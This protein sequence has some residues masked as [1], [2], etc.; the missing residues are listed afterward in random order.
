MKRP[1][2]LSKNY[3]R[4]FLSEAGKIFFSILGGCWLLTE[5]LTFFLPDVMQWAS[6]NS[7]VFLSSVTLALLVAIIYSLMKLWR[8]IGAH[9]ELGPLVIPII[10]TK[11][12]RIQVPREVMA[13]EIIKSF[14]AATYSERKFCEK[15]TLVI[16][17]EDHDEHIDLKELGNY[18]HV[19][20]IQKRWQKEPVGESVP[21]EE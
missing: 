11:F 2:F 13:T 3:W 15:L 16:T 14:I 7:W 21:T 8:Y 5:M 19:H 20:A 18:L 9:G 6:G 4:A 17:E 12:A 1:V 10:G